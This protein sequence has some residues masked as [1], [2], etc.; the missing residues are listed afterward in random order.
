MTVAV[1]YCVTNYYKFAVILIA[2]LFLNSVDE[3]ISYMN[4]FVRPKEIRY[5]TEILGL[6]KGY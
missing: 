6:G 4:M 3:S 2:N 5:R 1:F